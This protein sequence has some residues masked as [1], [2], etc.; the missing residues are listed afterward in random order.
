MV[1][2]VPASISLHLLHLPPLP[3]PPYFPLPP[4][5]S[6]CSC[7]SFWFGGRKDIFPF[8]NI[9]FLDCASAPPPPPHLLHH[10]LLLHLLPS[11]S[12]L[13][14]LPPGCYE[15]DTTVVMTGF[16]L[17]GMPEVEKASIQV[18]SLSLSPFSPSSSPFSPSSLPSPPPP[19]LCPL[20]SNRQNS[21][22]NSLTWLPLR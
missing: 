19:T 5:S 15:N 3:S 7:I 2:D 6:S 20:R 16:L 11:T 8:R 12:S 14:I 10:L 17:I 9:P 13:L 22:G 4:F 18:L 1:Y 21:S